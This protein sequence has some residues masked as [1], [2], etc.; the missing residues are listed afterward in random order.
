MFLDFADLQSKRG[1]SGV[2]RER[3]REGKKKQTK[4]KKI[5]HKRCLPSFFSFDDGG[6]AFLSLLL[7]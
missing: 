1:G 7:F 5:T 4:K 3:E 6:G 2:R